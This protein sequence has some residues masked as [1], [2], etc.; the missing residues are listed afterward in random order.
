MNENLG[1]RR[2]GYLY[3]G[4]VALLALTLLLMTALTSLASPMSQGPS[5]EITVHKFNDLNGNGV[6]DPGEPDIAGWLMRIYRWDSTG[7]YLVREG[8]T[9]SNGTVTFTDLT[10]TRYKVWE[11]ALECWEPTVGV[12]SYIWDGGYYTVVDLGEGESAFVEIGNT[13]IC[14]PTKTATPTKTPTDTPTD[15]PTVTDTPTDTP[16]VTDTPTDTPTVTD[17]PT[18]T[19]TVTD[20]PTDTPTVTDTPTD[21]PTVTDTPTDTPTVTDTP[22]ATSTSTAT[23]PPAM[24]P[25][26][27]CI[28]Y[29][30]EEG[31]Y[32]AYFGYWNTSGTAVTIPIGAENRFYPSPMDRGQP[33]TFL[34]GHYPFA[35]SV[36]FDGN[37]LS[38]HLAGSVASMGIHCPGIWPAQWLQ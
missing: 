37:P 4:V 17:T 19:P 33:T 12:N 15:T 10:P 18:D 25:I 29:N 38:W 26:A 9:D 16:T 36:R 24:G 34:L 13:Y 20:T 31:D 8:W 5:G 3:L 2:K 6:Q 11:Q 30:V 27:E 7:L 22:T 28:E 23:P 35:F 1:K 32:T 21:T 14:V